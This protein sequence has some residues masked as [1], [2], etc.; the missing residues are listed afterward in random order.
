MGSRPRRILNPI[1]GL[2]PVDREQQLVER[3]LDAARTSACATWREIQ[4]A[5]ST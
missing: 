3:G 4:L 5:A 1:N 2:D